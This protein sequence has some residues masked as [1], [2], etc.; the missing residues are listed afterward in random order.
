[1]GATRCTASIL[2]P[3]SQ[4]PPLTPRRLASCAA[5][6]DHRSKINYDL[7]KVMEGALDEC[8]QTMVML[9]Q[10]EMLRDLLETA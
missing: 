9:D 3:I 10:Q 8:I 7:N 2:S 1:M 4:S 6:A 5:P